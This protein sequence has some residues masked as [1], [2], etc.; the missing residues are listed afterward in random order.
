[1]IIRIL[2]TITLIFSPLL[3][4]ASNLSV[5]NTFVNGSPADADEVNANFTAVETAVNDNDARIAALEPA[6]IPP[7]DCDADGPDPDSDS[8]PGESGSAL[9]DALDAAPLAGTFSVVFDGTC[10]PV[11][12]TRSWTNI[13]GTTKATSI[14]QG[15][16]GFPTIQINNAT[17]VVVG[18]ATINGG[19]A[20]NPVVNIQEAG[21][22]FF[23][24]AIDGQTT[25][26]TGV[27]VQ[28]NSSFSLLNSTI[29]GANDDQLGVFASS[30]AAL[31]DNNQITAPNGTEA[32]G[33]IVGISSALI[34][35]GT[36]NVI[37]GT[38]GD[39]IAL[40]IETS[41]SFDQFGDGI[42]FNG[43]IEV[44]EGSSFLMEA[45]S[46][47]GNLNAVQNGSISIERDEPT[48]PLISVTGNVNINNNSAITLD[49]VD[50]TG[51]V[52]LNT[53]SNI[54]TY[55]TSISGSVTMYNMS[56]F[57][58]FDTTV[59]GGANL[60]GFTQFNISEDDGSSTLAGN[61]TVNFGNGALLNSGVAFGSA[62]FTCNGGSMF[63]N[64]LGGGLDACGDEDSD[65]VLNWEDQC[66]GSA[67]IPPTGCLP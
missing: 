38:S 56:V 45:G 20:D 62:N 19:D 9:Q 7:V 64:D 63:I 2:F 15:T 5:P 60:G 8:S 57:D 21:V 49:G 43:D 66:L 41:S 31:L 50:L 4:L 54:V 33:A 61:V 14:I 35:K 25:N 28:H 6:L 27:L 47:T 58:G 29:T 3:A 32:V 16:T 52:S 51:N 67:G 36:G 65:T 11:T 55:D 13:L 23:D 37:D 48:D 24:V 59:N 10:D 26:E 40:E 30:S 46:I 53:L 42:T 18:T 44:L 22:N 39:G 34:S 12:V 17:R 1:M